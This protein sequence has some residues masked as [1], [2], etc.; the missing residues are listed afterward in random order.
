M[1][2]GLTG[3]G[4]DNDIAVLQ[5]AAM[6]RACVRLRPLLEDLQKPADGDDSEDADDLVEYAMTER[7]LSPV[8]EYLR[9]CAEQAGGLMDH[10][11][12]VE[13]GWVEPDLS[14][15]RA[16]A[17]L[18]PVGMTVVGEPVEADDFAE[19]NQLL[20]VPTARL[21]N[22]AVPNPVD[23]DDDDDGFQEVTLRVAS[24]VR[25]ADEWLERASNDQL[26]QGVQ[27]ADKMMTALECLGLKWGGYEDRWRWVGRLAPTA[28]RVMT[29]LAAVMENEYL[30]MAVGRSA[31][32]DEIA[33]VGAILQGRPS[34]ALL[35]GVKT[36][37]DEALP[38]IDQH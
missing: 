16:R 12:L 13:E 26:I 32:R 25:E 23:N 15:T 28:P 3:K 20:D 38:E 36:S 22:V 4:R 11:P 19:L 7:R 6:G 18:L 30:P 2:A 14:R 29:A 5:L 10:R 1:A 24:L 37:E 33:L 8:S 34:M 35:E 31:P 17:A 27:A 21:A 9:M